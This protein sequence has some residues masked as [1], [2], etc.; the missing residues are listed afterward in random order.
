[1]HYIGHRAE[2]LETAILNSLKRVRWSV[3]HEACL[4][5]ISIKILSSQIEYRI[6]EKD[7]IIIA[8]VYSQC[9]FNDIE[10]A[11]NFEIKVSHAVDSV[12]EK[13]IKNLNV[14]TIEI[15]ISSIL[16][17]DEIYSKDEIIN[18]IRNN[19][20]ISIIHLNDDLNKV[21]YSHHKIE[22][23]LLMQDEQIER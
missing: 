18:I 14:N 20:N 13:K 2:K 7:Q 21:L 10:T 9:L 16:N 12:K 22:K 6:A 4:E 1:L 5:H 3:V 8:D 23:A 17:N 19:D 11:I 15:D